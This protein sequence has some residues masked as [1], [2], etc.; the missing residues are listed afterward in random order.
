MN[1]GGD[2]TS[3][4]DV[5]D[6]AASIVVRE[7]AAPDAKQDGA[8]H[9]GLAH[10]LLV[11]LDY[12]DGDRQAAPHR[13][14]L[15]R[16]GARFRRLFSMRAADAPGLVALGAEV[17]PWWVVDAPV[18][19]VCGVGL[20]FRQAFESCIGE[21]VEYLSQFA[22]PH[23]A[24][25]SMPAQEALAEAT[26][27][28]R[29]LWERLAACRR[30]PAAP[31]TDWALAADLADGT[32]AWLPADLCFRRPADVCTIAPPWPLSTGCG[33][34]ADP[35]D[36][37]LHGLL[38]LIERDAVALWLRGGLRARQLAPGPG[39]ALLGRLRGEVS[40]RRT[41][42]LDITTDTGVPAVAAVACNDDGFGLCRGY[43][44]R[45]TLAAAADAALME[46]V[47]ME[48]AHR[49]SATKHAKRG[50]EALNEID[51][52]HI[53]RYTKVDVAAT[54]SLHPLAPP[55]PSRD[56]LSYN[57]IATL[58]ELRRR[59]E[60]VGLGVYALNLTKPDLG[61]S[62][63]RSFAPGL[64]MSL[65]AS[66]GPRLLAAAERSGADPSEVVLI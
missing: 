27:S 8:K 24:V 6:A 36:A 35:L 22:A 12:L 13:A 40:T 64:E 34:G 49:L 59:L 46:L 50:V 30:D 17:A 54:P 33:A 43:A 21:G 7:T 25:H 19:S 56:L 32:P 10:D 11:R 60:I 1:A 51:R 42:L 52:Q 53:S 23:D 26:V 16:A 45:P 65:A 57:K 28:L 58:A 37:T 62:V 41:W 48:L 5:L 20:S 3:L 55:S 29:A 4:T 61:I 9:D 18:G 39:A 38:E 15:L 31:L 14:A 2:T 63:T 66:P 47:Q 44:C